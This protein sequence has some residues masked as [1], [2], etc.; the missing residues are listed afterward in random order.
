MTLD[1]ELGQYSQDEAAAPQF[2]PKVFERI[3]IHG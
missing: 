2:H 1:T 3:K